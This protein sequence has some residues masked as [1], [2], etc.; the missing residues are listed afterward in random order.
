MT[1]FPRGAALVLAAALAAAGCGP[2]A[3]KLFPVSGRVLVGETPVPAGSFQLRADPTR[4]N[5]SM[6]IP[7]GVI[8]PDGSFDLDTNG[9]KGSPAGWWK[10]VVVADN[11]QVFDPPPSPVWPLFPEGFEPPKPLV[12]HRYLNTNSSDVSVEVV[13][14]PAED[15]YVIR[16]NP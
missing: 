2:A 5:K 8:R 4:G 1:P 14:N 3:P 10:V 16:L 12:N 13:E 9:Q 6:E 11:F 15:A 7:S